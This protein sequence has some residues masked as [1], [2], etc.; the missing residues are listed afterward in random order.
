[1][2]KCILIGSF[3]PISTNISQAES[4]EKEGYEV[5][6]YDYRKRGHNH[7]EIIELAYK[8]RPDF[9]FFSKCNGLS[10]KAID[11][12]N[13][14]TKTILWYMDPINGFNS[15]LQEKIK[16]ATISCFALHDPYIEGLK[17][18][19]K[20][21]FIHEGF[22]PKYDYPY[23]NINKEYDVSFIGNL[24]HPGNRK[25]YYDKYK[26]TLISNAYNEKHAQEV[27][28]SK[29]NL[30]FT[31]GGASDRVYKI[32]AAKGFLLTQPWPEMEKDFV[33]KKDLDIFESEKEFEEKLDFYLREKELREE[34]AKHGHNTVQKFSRE[35]FAKRILEKL[36]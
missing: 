32:L 5:I 8:H 2:P 11:G 13:I 16:R 27:A 7:Q 30:N 9:V 6:R 36:K 24:G 25:K 3:L 18:S 22:D 15:E 33:V 19:K 34:I 1:M 14:I 4:F 21:F 17:Y 10:H 31:L 29:I 28:K 26:F 23:E 12:C 20:C 35:N